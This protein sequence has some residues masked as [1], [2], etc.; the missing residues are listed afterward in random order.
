MLPLSYADP[1]ICFLQVNIDIDALLTSE[2]LHLPVDVAM[3][4]EATSQ[5]SGYDGSVSMT[6]NV[7][8]T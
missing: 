5:K 2:E 4:R 8:Y 6:F 1:Y 3:S 7:S